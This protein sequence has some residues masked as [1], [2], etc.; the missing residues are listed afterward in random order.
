MID[1]EY[2]ARIAVTE[3]FVLDEAQLSSLNVYA[4]QLVSWNEKVNLT[5]IVKPEEIAVKHF[6]DSLLLLKSVDIKDSASL[7]DIGAGAGF[8]SLPCKLLRSDIKLTMLDSLNKR[9]D[10][11]NSLTIELGVHA[12][13]IHGRAEEMGHKG[14]Y[15][16]RFDIVTARAVAHLRDLSEY[17]LP[18]VK[19]GGYFAPL[20]GYDIEAELDEAKKAI[21]ALGG[22]IVEVKKYTLPDESK[23]AIVV[24]KKISQTSTKYPRNHGKMKKQPI[25]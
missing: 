17:C 6:L 15:R 13:C 12:N 14:E 2:M 18:F 22:E 8:P 7:L 25:I 4:E 1:R 20:K 9:I 21:E 16:E 5:A 3:G 10:F 19:V 24:I 11:L 23:R